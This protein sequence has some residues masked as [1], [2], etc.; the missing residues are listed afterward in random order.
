MRASLPFTVGLV[1]F[2][3]TLAR[4]G[5]KYN[6]KANA[7]APIAASAMTETI[8]PPEVL[9][10]LTPEFISPVVGVLC[11]PN[12]PDVTGRVF[13]LGA[14][15]VSELRWQRAKGANFKPD[16]SFTPSAVKEKWAE[17]QDFGREGYEYPKDMAGKDPI[18]LL[19]ISKKIG[20]NKAS[21]PEVT[22][23]GQTVIVTGAGA[24]LGRA[25]ALMYAKLGA[26][27]VVND[28]S[29]KGADSVVS[30]IEKSGGKAVAAPFSAEEGESI[31][32]VA[33][34]KFGSVHALIANA[35]ILR[36]K[37]FQAM[38]PTE[39]DQVIAVHLRG[40]YKCAKACWPIFQEQK[41][42]RIITTASAVG[43]YG[44]FG[45]AN[46]STAKAALIGLTKSLAIEGSRYNIKV[47]CISPSAGTAMTETIWPEEM[48]KMF[49]PD[50][51]APVV[52]YL[53][54]NSCKDTGTVYEV[55]AGWAAQVR[56][57]R[58]G[59]FCFP[60]DKK[61]QPED[62]LAKW[63]TITDFKDGR[64]THPASAAESQQQM[65]QNFENTSKGSSSSKSGSTSPSPYADDEDP[66]V[67]RKAKE[68]KIEPSTFT[69]D[70]RDV[71]LY[72][73]GVG[74]KASELK[75]VFEGADEFQVLPTFGVIPAFSAGS[76]SMDFVPNFNPVSGG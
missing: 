3:R 49:K 47:N 70:D 22:F 9:K 6:I 53:S 75:L 54:S 28:V 38:T 37:S 59:G 19:E 11:A 57:E 29:S 66:E 12:G 4:E 72:N 34:E 62:V 65:F 42:G 31:V 35:G 2:T 20:S 24:G 55:F 74:A 32:K 21:Q 39:W 48:V 10:H 41:Y 7:I 73:L 76:L 50:F 5:A 71:M 64:A 36:D 15:F 1:G 30:E 25:Y 18:G 60:N 13:E 43:L 51:V 26:N 14:G 68:V 67:I 46:Y 27:V 61:L 56:W 58:T 45:Q 8:M 63:S 52:G 17:V 69:Y 40:T 23:K 44:N 16:E 33:M